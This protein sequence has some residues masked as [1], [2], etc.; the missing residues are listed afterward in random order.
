MLCLDKENAVLHNI[1]E[2]ENLLHLID[3]LELYFFA[4]NCLLLMFYR[5]T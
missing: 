1:V 5:R 3:N 2:Q 4:K